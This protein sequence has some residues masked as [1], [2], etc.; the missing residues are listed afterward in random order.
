[1][2]QLIFTGKERPHEGYKNSPYRPASLPMYSGCMALII[3][4]RSIH[5]I[6]N[7]WILH[8]L[9]FIAHSF[10][11]SANPVSR[12]EQHLYR[13]KCRNELTECLT[14]NLYPLAGERPFTMPK[15][16]KIETSQRHTQK[17]PHSTVTVYIHALVEAG[18]DGID[19]LSIR[20]KLVN[21]KTKCTVD[22]SVGLMRKDMQVEFKNSLGYVMLEMPNDLFDELTGEFKSNVKKMFQ[23][24][25][26]QVYTQAFRG[27][28][29]TQ[30]TVT[31][32]G[33]ELVDIGLYSDERASERGFNS[34]MSI[35]TS[36]KV[37]G[38]IRYK[39]N[40]KPLYIHSLTVMFH[41]VERREAEFTVFLNSH[42]DW[43]FIIYFF[44]HIPLY[45][46]ELSARAAS[47]CYQVFYLARQHTADIKERGRF[48]ISL[49]AV[50][51][52]L[53]IPLR[54]T[55]QA[56][57]DIVNE[58][59][60]AVD[61]LEAA[62]RTHFHNEDLEL[63]IINCDDTMPPAQFIEAINKGGAALE[64]NISGELAKPFIEFEELKAKRLKEAIAKRKAKTRKNADNPK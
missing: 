56:K 13:L 54:A 24:V 29:L 5:W 19:E 44:S 21:H 37:K 28:E 18:R 61:E 49:K 12:D 17:Q 32:S 14:I 42:I 25:L 31:F 38:E 47:L 15:F 51:N 3:W 43:N 48:T 30:D 20:Q 34:A 64:V 36:I 2:K 41:R 4:I 11:S 27:G 8:I 60:R 6:L 45:Y 10:N 62:H 39:P 22:R 35:L 59:F 7:I 40:M 63:F 33:H 55:K 46:Y 1:M 57:R 53:S 26:E 50:R 58:F 23:F 9:A 52:A 16:K